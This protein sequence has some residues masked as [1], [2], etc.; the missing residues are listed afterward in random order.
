MGIP[1]A[2]ELGA[3][4]LLQKSFLPLE[5]KDFCNKFLA[6]SSKAIGI[7]GIPRIIPRWAFYLVGK[8]GSQKIVTQH[9]APF[10]SWA[11][12]LSEAFASSL[13]HDVCHCVRVAVCSWASVFHVPTPIL[14]SITRNTPM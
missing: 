10:S 6:P 7:S 12:Y 8:I 2:F 5:R 11:W 3:K 1:M 14:L 4:N 9:F 13:H